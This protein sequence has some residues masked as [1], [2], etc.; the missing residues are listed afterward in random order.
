VLSSERVGDDAAATRAA[1]ERALAAADVVAIAGGVSVGPHDH[2]K[3]ALA[4]LGVEERFWG[5]RIRP[6]KP[7]WF[8][9]HG[10]TLVF[11]LPGNPV[12]A[13]VIFL[14]L[15]MGALAA[16]QGRSGALARVRA[17]LS[18]PLPRNAGRTEA[19]RVRLRHTAGGLE[20]TPTGPQGSHVTTSLLGADG[21]AFVPEG[22]GE[23]AAGSEIEVEPLGVS[24]SF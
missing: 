4:A 20:A 12:S 18:E 16:Q 19:V 11:G 24:W 13:I 1:L 14:T 15:A 7:T 3:G 17:T 8:G 21:L 23:L 10:D 22:E 9:T 2:V 5:I 6:G